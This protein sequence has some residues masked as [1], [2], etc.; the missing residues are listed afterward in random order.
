MVPDP[1]RT[2]EPSAYWQQRL[3]RAGL[4]AAGVPALGTGFNRWAYRVR[5]AGFKRAVRRAMAT[6]PAG[7]VLDIGSGTGFY[8]D[9]WRRLGADRVVGSDLTAASIEQIR[10][11]HPGLETA[12]LDIGAEEAVP[13]AGLKPGSFAAISIMD[14]LFH[15]LDEDRYRTAFRNLATLLAP[16]GIVVFS[17]DMAARTRRRRI[18]VTRSARATRRAWRAAG[19]QRVSRSPLFVLM[20]SP[21]SGGPRARRRWRRLQR[22]LAGRPRVGWAVGAAIYPLERALVAGGRRAPST[23]ILVC[24]KPVGEGG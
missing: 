5:A 10:S 2:V 1:E 23:E 22:A 15:I 9:Q 4:E 8:I 21:S 19:L 6:P 13:R 16:D 14:V 3:D 7:P 11:S 24:R 20:N 18:K 17:E 12:Q